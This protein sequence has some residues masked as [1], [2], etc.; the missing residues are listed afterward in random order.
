MAW[1]FGLA[2]FLAAFL[3]FSAQPMIGKMV[4]P[5]LGGTPG[6]WNT[7]LVFFQAALLAGYAYAHLGSLGRGVRRSFLIHAILLVLP[8]L[9]LPITIPADLQPPDSAGMA[10]PLWLFWVLVV[11]AG[12]PLFVVSATAPL[13]QRWFS[14]SRH[15]DAHDPYF[16]YAASNSGSLAGLFA[17]P[18]LI[19]PF[20]SLSRQRQAW[21]LGFG[22][23][24]LLVLA[25][26]MLVR[27]I[28][29]RSCQLADQDHVSTSRPR[30][31]PGDIAR[32]A[33][34]AFIPS[35]WLLGVTTYITTDLVAMPLLWT[36]LLGIYLVTYILAF[37]RTSGWW[38]R[39]AAVSLPLVVVPLV[40]VLGAGLVQLFWIPLHL[41]AFFAGAMVC[42]GR[43]AAS[44]PEATHATAFYLAVA[45]GGVL[46]G[47]FNS[48]LAPLVFD[49]LIE[50]PLAVVL[51]CLVTPGI[52][53]VVKPP[54]P[55]SRLADLLLPLSVFGLV[56]ILVKS[57]AEMVDSIPGMLGVMVAS[58]L[59]LYACVTGLRRRVRF[60]LTVAG[61]LLASG[62][63]RSPGGRL[64]HRER[65]FFGTL[66]VLHDPR[67]NV[68]RLLEGSTL[69]GQ[70]SLDAV[71]RGEPSTYFTRS[72]PIG[73]VFA[74]LESRL[75]EKP[76]E[77]VGIIGLGAGTLACYARSGQ[78][79]VFYEIDPAV[80]RI[81]RNPRY[82][83]YLN[84]S[85]ARGI[86]PAVVVGDARLRIREAPEQGYR[87]IVVDAF[88]SDVLPVHL[89]SREAIR[90]YESR[91][92]PGGILAINLSSRYLDL[93][94]VVALQASDAGM[95]CRICHDIDVTD[96][97][98]AAG[99]QP[100]IWAVL[101][102][103]ESD[104][105]VLADSPRWQV[106]VPRPRARVW[107]D[108]YSDVASY[109]VPWGRRFPTK[110]TGPAR[111]DSH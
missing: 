17:Y 86:D 44:R 5:V 45:G 75:T 58:G 91:L 1:L 63:A 78:R 77:R 38:T 49:R 89:I 111:Q 65:D 46:G 104:L 40:L 101:A 84:D 9:V 73:Q 62:L 48:L 95:V 15:P 90:L 54:R 25:S 94:P 96:A 28:R 108:D 16:L 79:W 34:L 23:L 83:T 30:P 3:L 7:C 85:Q 87:L 61:F 105:G 92:A 60:A 93:D 18:L 98:R 33:A 97:E 110:A 68:H 4:L 59:G 37:A 22:V 69:H 43:L 103:T 76:G 50:Y 11:A 107:T 100:S 56:A 42:H 80:V 31:T 109:L 20:L 21:E 52:A 55:A 99:K 27:G 24:G 41:L 29:F 67:A 39:A 57:P 74:A 13:L 51:A 81:A 47:L 8:F 10:L 72:G 106:P 35:S 2:M 88:S 12:L 71:A 26:G 6:V 32:W 70:Q 64:I 14:L 102:R 36:I 66:R 82:F 53:G 19:E